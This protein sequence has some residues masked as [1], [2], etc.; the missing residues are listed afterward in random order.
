[1]DWR[2]RRLRSGGED[3]A[4]LHFRFRVV[5][6]VVFRS[7]LLDFTAFLLGS[8]NRIVNG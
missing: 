5:I 1:M 4:A 3:C 2:W 8:L 6:V 7:C